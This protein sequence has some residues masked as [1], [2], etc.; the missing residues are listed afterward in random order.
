MDEMR[1]AQNRLEGARKENNSR[2]IGTDHKVT[3]NK[4][5]RCGQ[6]WAASREWSVTGYREQGLKRKIWRF[7]GGNNEEFCKIWG[8][9]GGDYEEWCLLGYDDAVIT[10]NVSREHAASILSVKMLWVPLVRNKDATQWR[11]R[12]RT[13]CKGWYI[14][15]SFTVEM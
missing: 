12:K 4:V 3:Q 7:H 9:H 2:Y 6:H 5:R 1:N 10:T 11:T 13:S 8:F 14:V 15:V